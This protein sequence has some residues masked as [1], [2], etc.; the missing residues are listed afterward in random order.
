LSILDWVEKS[1]PDKRQALEEQNQRRMLRQV[2]QQIP[3]GND[4][5]KCKN[6]GNRKRVSF[7]VGLQC[8]RGIQGQKCAVIPLALRRG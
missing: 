2:Q 8:R 1:K 5:K 3:K 7:P 6:N 4:R